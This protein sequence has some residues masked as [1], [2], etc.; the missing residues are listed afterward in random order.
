[1]EEQVRLVKVRTQLLVAFLLLAVVPLASIVLYSYS[2]SERAFKRAVAAEAQVLAEETGVRLSTLREELED[3]LAGLEVLPV[4]NL[5]MGESGEAGA[6]YT[7]LMV[8]M[9]ESADLVDLIEF[10]PA[11]PADSPEG[12]P[13]TTPEP[14][15]I[16]PSRVLAEAIDK[17]STQQ[18]LLEDSGLSERYLQEAIDQAVR[19]RRSLQEGELSALDASVS[20]TERLLGSEFTIAVRSGR[21]IIGH[22]KAH[23]PA[24]QI[25]RQV[26]SRTPRSEGEI[27]YAVDD[28]R[29]LYVDRPEDRARLEGVLP[30]AGEDG[31]GDGASPRGWIIA[32]TPDPESGLT[33]GIARPIGGALKE[34]R[35]TAVRSLAYGLSLVLVALAGVFVL[36]SRMTQNLDLLTAGAEKLA[37]GDL[38]TRV[39]VRSRNEFGRLA[40]TFNRMAGELAEKQRRLLEEE[41][42]RREQEVER[43]L[44]EAE[45]QRKGRDLEEARQFQMSLLP[46]TLP[47][48][49]DLEVAVFM[50]TAT[51]VGGDYYDFFPSASGA[52]TA[53][54]GDAAGHGARAGTMVTVV[55]GLLSAAAEEDLPQTLANATSAIKRMELGRMNMALTLLRID[56]RRIAVSAAGM[57]PAL[58]YSRRHRRLQEIELVGTPLGSLADASYQ[59]WESE[60]SGGDTVL[61]MTDGFPELLN[62]DEEAMGY[63]RVR[64]IFSASQAKSPQQIIDELSGEA[65][66]WTGGRPPHDDIT[67]VVLRV[68]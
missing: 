6:V 9:G 44:L 28:E 7:E 61:L 31:L 60:I 52:L 55:K 67:F 29:T 47:Q 14:F 63:E 15:F 45:N 51:E 64:S 56:G 11:A 25:V 13:T 57:P 41:E 43:R 21:E 12:M 49:P 16:Y 62:G 58:L 35:Q 39:T 30:A 8:R 19:E 65:E 59:L 1:V 20:E 66:A 42:L 17:L 24:S 27:P 34:I 18:L 46:K 53:A 26:L 36:S 4:R 22:L 38:E 10:T 2:A 40:G 48:H 5:Q 23:V 3:R 37:G 32:E 68:K 33:F 54:I 50:K